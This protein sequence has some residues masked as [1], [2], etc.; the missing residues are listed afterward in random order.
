ME[1]LEHSTLFDRMPHVTTLARLQQFALI[2]SKND[3][4]RHEI[5]ERISIH[6]DIMNRINHQI[7]GFAPL[8][9]W[10]TMLPTRTRI[11]SLFSSIFGSLNEK[12]VK[13]M[14]LPE[15]HAVKF[16]YQNQGLNKI[17]RMFSAK[18]NT[19]GRLVDRQ[20]HGQGKIIGLPHREYLQEYLALHTAGQLYLTQAKQAIPVSYNS[21]VQFVAENGHL[22]IGFA[23]RKSTE[24]IFNH[25]MNHHRTPQSS[26]DHIGGPRSLPVQMRDVPIQRRDEI[27]QVVTDMLDRQTRLPPSGTTM[28][29]PRLT[30]AWPG[31]KIPN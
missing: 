4:L 26:A 19:H 17:I 22:E 20:L 6:S 12:N 27:R 23:P 15:P 18:H 29:D 11:S 5:F 8:R 10:R 30:P 3:R 24:R 7:S 25:S 14:K 16:R 31:L 28:F 13:I 2:S 9:N 21:N 1:N